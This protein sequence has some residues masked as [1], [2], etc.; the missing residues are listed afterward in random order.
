[1]AKPFVKWVGGKSRLVRRL[2]AKAPREMRTYV[3]PF[4]GG[5]AMFFALSE[6][7]DAGARPTFASVIADQNAELVATYRAVKGDVESVIAALRSYTYDRDLFYET[8]ALATEG[9]TDTQRAAR[10]I[11]LNKTCFNGLWRVNASGKFNVPFGRY[12]D[13]RILDEENLRAAS[14]ALRK[15]K[16]VSGDF[17]EATRKVVRGDFVYFDPPYVPLT[18]TAMFTDY[19]QGGFGAK[20]QERLAVELRRL[21][22]LGVHVMLS[23]ADTRETRKL[24]EGFAMHVVKVGRPINS[25]PTKRG[26]AGEIVVTTWDAPGVYKDGV[27]TTARK[28]GRV[29][30]PS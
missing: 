3:E 23:N 5:G 17:A 2:L 13:P 24:Y 25:D 14:E 22:S 10:L 19:V 11:F 30:V 1:M 26:A 28:R 20:D 9:M 7:A 12:K 15:T 16:I 29:V 27:R 18:R 6:E 21:K 4:V 8:R